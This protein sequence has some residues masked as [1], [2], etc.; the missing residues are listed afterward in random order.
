MKRHLVVEAF[1]LSL[2]AAAA[3]FA[4][5]RDTASVF[6]TVTDAQVAVI[7]GATVTL[8]N[9]ATGLVRTAESNESGDFLFPLVPV[10]SYKLSAEKSGFKTYVKTGILTRAN[11]N[12]KVNISMELGEVQQHITVEA[13]IAQVETRSPTLGQVV[14]SKRVVELPLNGRNPADLTLLA[15][16]VAPAWGSNTGDGGPGWILVPPGQKTLSVNGSRNS[17]VRFTLDGG[18]HL[19]PL[20]N[21]NLPFPFPEAVEEFSVQSS[22]MTPEMGASSAGSVNIVTKSGTNNLHGSGFWFVRNTA[23]NATNFFSHQEDDLKR[24]QM[25]FTLGGPIVKNKLFLFGGYQKLTNRWTGGSERAEPLTAAQREGDFSAY[26]GQIYDPLTGEPFPNN[27]IPSSRLSRAA[28]NLLAVVPLPDADGFYRYAVPRAEN[29]AQYVVRG[30]YTPSEK[31]SF[32]LRYLGDHQEQPGLQSQD[33]IYLNTFELN[34]PTRAGTFSHTFVASPSIVIHSRVTANHFRSVG[35]GGFQRSFRDFGININPIDKDMVIDIP[36]GGGFGTPYKVSYNRAAYEYVHD[37][38]MTK[39]NHTM[40][41]G[42]NV[43]WRQ[44]NEDTS[45]HGSG[46]FYFDG[47]ATGKDQFAGYDRADFML[48]QFAY[49]QQNNGEK[50]NRRQLLRGFY[51]NDV[52]RLSR[53]FNLTLG[54]RYE[55]YRFVLD[56]MDRV[57]LFDVGNYRQ[58]IRSRKYLNAPAGLLYP[59]DDRPGGGTIPRTGADSD[60]NNWAPHIGF[61]WS[62]FADGKTSI[63]GGYALFYDAPP[64]FTQNNGNNVAPFSYSVEF[65]EGLL[66]DPFRGREHLNRFPVTDF[67]PDTPFADPLYTLVVDRNFILPDIHNWNLT[68]EREILS[69]TILRI[70][71]VGTKSTHLKGEYDQNAPIYNPNLSFAENRATI[72]ERRPFRGFQGII[73]MMHGLGSIHH[74]L[75]ISADRRYARGVTASAS[76]TWGRTIDYL[77]QNRWGGEARVNAFDFS[78]NRGPSDWDRTHRFVGSAV[79]DV[80]GLSGASAPRAMKAIANGWRLSGIVTIQSGSPFTIFS[81]GNPMAGGGSVRANLVGDGYPILNPGRSKGEKIARYFDVNR[82]ANASPGTWGSLGRNALVG[83]GYGNVDVSLVKGFKL[84]FKSEFARGE[85]R[86]DVFN[87]FNTTHLGNPVTG[88]TSSHFGEI[89]GTNGDPRILQLGLKFAF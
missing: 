67:K 84:P 87:L 24:N 82:F 32:M 2:M 88:L 80:P 42:G 49:F 15:P 18:E 40:S 72:D 68:V 45:W 36:S 70:G 25:G 59:G 85:F 53:G 52:W 56:T 37:W 35:G 6:G 5:T 38:I 28:L 21:S 48:G 55:P 77:S 22:N 65:T 75:Q 81:T 7:P 16:G 47:H 33:N 57:Q 73:R 74:S 11:D 27:R 71:Y 54:F 1:L 64:L 4:Q 12:V 30:D 83:P 29:G 62:P 8:T 78:M 14:E 10:G 63:R 61:A 51:F 89:L 34:N 60:Y 44:Y 17:S 3:G 41:F 69:G 23:L 76:Y 26:D 86:C 66:D 31:H 46:Y 43:T 39:G 9:I 13:G 50:E 20:V 58:G 19:D 79:W